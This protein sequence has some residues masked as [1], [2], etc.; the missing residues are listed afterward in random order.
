MATTAEGAASG[1]WTYID[2]DGETFKITSGRKKK[3]QLMHLIIS[4]DLEK[5]VR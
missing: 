2:S 4:C 5:A 3:V 1:E